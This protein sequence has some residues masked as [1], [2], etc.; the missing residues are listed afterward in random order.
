[1]G[2]IEDD[3]IRRVR[4]A[5]D[6]V[7][8]VAETVVLKQKGRLFWGCCPFHNEKTPSF[9]IDPG[10][11]LWHCFGCG[12][13]GDV[14]GYV[15]EREKLE[16]PEAVRQLADRA[17]I[18]I[19]E[20]QGGMPRGQRQRI[21]E[22]C[23]AAE[24]FFHTQLM[25]S[26]DSGA[27]SAREYL[28]KR[29]F[30]S[31]PSKGWR[32][33][34]APGHGKLSAHLQGKGFTRDELVQ[35]NLAFVNEN[36]RMVDRFFNRV[37]FPVHDLQGRTIAFGGRVIGSGEPKYLN[38]SETPVFHKSS[39]MF[40]IHKAKSAIVS[41]GTAV[42]V[43][44]YTDVIALHEAGICNAVATLGTA[45]TAQHVKL[46]GRFAS[47]IVY[48]FDGDAAGQKAAMRAAEFIDWSSAVESGRNPIE[49]KVTVLPDN[50][51]PA[52]FV[53]AKGAE[54]LLQQVDKAQPL[55]DFA[56]NRTLEGFD[57]TKPALKARAMEEALKILLPVRGSVIATDYVNSIADRLNLEYTVVSHALKELKAPAVA[58][59][60]NDSVPRPEQGQPPRNTAVAK[61]VEE[62]R[63][64]SRMEFELLSLCVADTALL[65]K[66]GTSLKE[67]H[68][69]DPR[70]QA[71]AAALLQ[72]GTQATPAQAYGTAV[73]VC[74]EAPALLAQA[75][76]EAEPGEEGQ[77]RARLLARAL[78]E[79][80]LEAEIRQAKAQMRDT[81]SLSPEEADALFEKT[82]GLQQQLVELRSG[83]RA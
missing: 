21:M 22:A 44:G 65:G 48:L 38:S 83:P 71:M 75:M 73:S 23:E 14:F 61:V 72:A 45:L 33:G 11:Q 78:R 60:E 3:D 19:K 32:L 2:R 26:K 81:G 42:V 27:A 31:G 70:A 7:Q 54:A 6:L 18:E 41:S 59:R 62:G 35:A 76:S 51:D 69:E 79:R 10:T 50:M 12:K 74:P 5:T 66:L 67:I 24:E 47:S 29:G 28:G 64:S 30:G 15:M 20:T 8:L 53:A 63:K 39:N 52:E 80:D 4:E 1:M 43:E 9:K 37:M 77:L 25:R 36:G 17:H 16:F 46:L 34:Y 49:L 13:G 68:W 57:L 56:I 58:R 55:L 40:G 82:V